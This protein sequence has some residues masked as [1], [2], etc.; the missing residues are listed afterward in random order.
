[1]EDGT[2][3]TTR[4]TAPPRSPSGVRVPGRTRARKAR[5]QPDS[6]AASGWVVALGPSCRSTMISGPGDPAVEP[7]RRQA[8]GIGKQSEAPTGQRRAGTRHDRAGASYADPPGDTP[9]RSA[10][11]G[12]AARCASVMRLVATCVATQ[13]CATKGRLAAARSSRCCREG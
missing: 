2:R 7:H 13:L 10:A 11:S 3:S 8:L 1:M 5:N 12:V 6:P 9:R 4:W